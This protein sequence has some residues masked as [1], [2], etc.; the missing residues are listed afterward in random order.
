MAPANRST[1]AWE[2]LYREPP[3]SR[4]PPSTWTAACSP[5]SKATRSSPSSSRFSTTTSSPT[6]RPGKKKKSAHATE[7]AGQI[8]L[9]LK[10]AASEFRLGRVFRQIDTLAWDD[11]S[12]RPTPRGVLLFDGE[13]LHVVLALW[14]NLA[15]VP[16]SAG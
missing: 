16:E 7:L 13:A 10:C 6:T 12:S 1:R 2:F 4:K 14:R 8:A 11:L 3:K 9:I 15:H 5:R